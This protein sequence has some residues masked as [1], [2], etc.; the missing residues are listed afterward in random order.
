MTYLNS[1]NSL[2][3]LITNFPIRAFFWILAIASGVR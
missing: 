1:L 3:R 2:N